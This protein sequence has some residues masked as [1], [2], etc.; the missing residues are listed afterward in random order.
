MKK[1]S[2]SRS[3]F[4]IR[5]SILTRKKQIRAAGLSKNRK[6]R[7]IN[8]KKTN[9]KPV[10]IQA[11]ETFELKSEKG[12]KE[13]LETIKLITEHLSSNRRIRLC[14]RK[15][16]N[17]QP[18]GTLYF[19]SSIESPLIEYPGK[20]DCS[21]PDDDIVEQL[22]QHIGFLEKLGKSKRKEITAENVVNWHFATGTDATTNAFQALLLQHQDAMGGELIRSELYD[23]MSEAVTNTKKH[24]YPETNKKPENRW[25]MFSQAENNQLTVAICDLGIGIPDSLLEKKEMSDYIRDLRG[26]FRIEQMH[27]RLIEV[28][29]SSNRSSTGLAYI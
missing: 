1:I 28:A 11:P 29:V 25:W 22:F 2:R 24:A 5:N 8:S 17:L 7:N 4:L 3:L 12:R 27:K 15:T 20:I 16:K 18:C 6:L 21:Y 19:V 26:L 14:F 9:L 10:P 13:I 23:C